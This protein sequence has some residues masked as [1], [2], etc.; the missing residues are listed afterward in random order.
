MVP[1]AF[2]QF[3]NPIPKSI[4]MVL[5]ISTCFRLASQESDPETGIKCQCFNY[6]MQSQGR[7]EI[8]KE[9]RQQGIGTRQGDTLLFWPLCYNEP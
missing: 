9:M 3:S 5:S 6:N 2:R 7:R 1:I 4:H 8:R